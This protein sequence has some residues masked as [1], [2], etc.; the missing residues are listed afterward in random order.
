MKHL[1]VKLAASNLALATL[2]AASPAMAD[3]VPAGTLI[4]NTAT[5]E[6]SDADGTPQT[7]DS[8]TVTVQ[9]D[10]LLDVTATWQ[11]GSAVTIGNAS[12]VLTFEI[13]NTGNGPEAFTLTADPSVTGNDFD[14]IIDG[15]AYDTNDNGIYDDGVDIVLGAGAATPTLAADT[16]LTVFVLV[17]SPTGVADGETSAVNLLAEAVTGTGAPGTSFAGQG[18]DGSNAVVG[19]T[20]AGAD[21]NGSLFA[22]LAG[23][24]LTK[25]ASVADPFGG[26]EAVPNAVVSFTIVARVGGSGSITGLTI[27]DAIPAGTTYQAATLRLDG[28]SL[29]DAADADAGEANSTGITVDVGSAAA[30]TSHTITFDVLID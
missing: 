12:A 4:E 21:T 2:L 30:G 19:A 11:D 20:G 15:I 22:R 23:L 29:S 24:T 16:A 27:T 18:A 3:G 6:F 10:E 26:A 25:S 8:N 1:G 13:T 9:V 14:V 17:T 5:A 7:I 28:A